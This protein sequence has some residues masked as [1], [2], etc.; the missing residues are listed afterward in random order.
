MNPTSQGTSPAPGLL[1]RQH[2]RKPRC[3]KTTGAVRGHLTTIHLTST[4]QTIRIMREIRGIREEKTLTNQRISTLI[5][6]QRLGLDQ[7]TNL[8]TSLSH[9]LTSHLQQQST[10]TGVE[11]GSSRIP[12]LTHLQGTI[13]C[14]NSRTRLWRREA[15]MASQPMERPSPLP[16]EKPRVCDK[17]PLFQTRTSSSI[18]N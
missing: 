11:R 17:T 12:S 10:K 6:P 7:S 8:W 1:S 3:L 2:L 18:T 16:R 9:P 14:L 5:T 13:R 4:H 15:V